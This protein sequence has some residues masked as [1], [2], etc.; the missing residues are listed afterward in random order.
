M[1]KSLKKAASF[2][3]VERPRDFDTLRVTRRL[4]AQGQQPTAGHQAGVGWEGGGA[5]SGSPCS[6]QLVLASCP[7]SHGAAVR[8]A[9]ARCG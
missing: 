2:L 8:G 5:S 4:E 9:T 6:E 7:R 3:C 1:E